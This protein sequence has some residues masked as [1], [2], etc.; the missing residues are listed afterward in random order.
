MLQPWGDD[1]LPDRLLINLSSLNGSAN[2]LR[3]RDIATSMHQGKKVI[4]QINK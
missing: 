1:H 4:I 2:C 3:N